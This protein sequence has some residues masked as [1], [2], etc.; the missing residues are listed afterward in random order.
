LAEAHRLRGDV[1]TKEGN[2]DRA[3]A[4]YSEAIR[5]DPRSVAS[6]RGRAEAHSRK[7][8]VDRAEVD[9][10]EAERLKSPAAR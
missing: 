2:L 8:E 10:R 1:C 9:R 7:G 4:S 5:L 6:Y 3:I